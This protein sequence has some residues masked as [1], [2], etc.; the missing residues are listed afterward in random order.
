MTER[1]CLLCFKNKVEKYQRFCLD[2]CV[3]I[4]NLK[5]QEK[6]EKRKDISA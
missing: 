3:K 5:E 1:F 6:K 2:C 4:F